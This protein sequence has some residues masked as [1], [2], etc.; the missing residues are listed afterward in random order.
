MLFSVFCRCHAG[1]GF[2]V[3][4]QAQTLWNEEPWP[5]N[6]QG[7]QRGREDATRGGLVPASWRRAWSSVVLGHSPLFSSPSWNFVRWLR[8]PV[9][10]HAELED[11][12]AGRG[13]DGMGQRQT[14]PWSVSAPSQ[15]QPDLRRFERWRHR[16]TLN[17]ACSRRRSF[18]ALARASNLRRRRRVS[19]FL[20][21]PPLGLCPARAC[22]VHARR[23]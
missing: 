5:D 23:I 16:A 12:W 18:S 3:D 17:G 20:P 6:S 10:G 11:G 7:M 8:H 13:C 2:K 19:C 21:D 1:A 14:T 22:N 9:C 15:M 4:T